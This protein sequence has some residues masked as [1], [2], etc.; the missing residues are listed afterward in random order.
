MNQNPKP[1]HLGPLLLTRPSWSEMG[2]NWNFHADPMACSCLVIIRYLLFI[3]DTSCMT[4]TC[5]HLTLSTHLYSHDSC[6]EMEYTEAFMWLN[7][8]EASFGLGRLPVEL[9]D[10]FWSMLSS[11][12]W[13][14]LMSFGKELL[15]EASHALTDPAYGVPGE[16]VD[17]VHVN[18][19]VGC[20]RCSHREGTSGKMCGRCT[21][22]LK[23]VENWW[24]FLFLSKSSSDLSDTT[25][26]RLPWLGHGPWGDTML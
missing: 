8:H 18:L 25:F 16:W 23:Q 2:V 9:T 26:Y 17:I 20:S 15:A 14:S 7:H 10:P 24:S 3:V 21:Q 13:G 5:I 6:T 1:P 22:A 12:G 11:K 19:K 4:C